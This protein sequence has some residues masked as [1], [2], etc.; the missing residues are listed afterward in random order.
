MGNGARQSG[1]SLAT[2]RLQPIEL[3]FH[4]RTVDKQTTLEL[5]IEV[6]VEI[7]SRPDAQYQGRRIPLNP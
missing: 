5:H 7:Q 3:D 6:D 2:R 4:Y 1:D